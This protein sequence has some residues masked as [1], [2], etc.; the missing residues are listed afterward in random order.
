MRFRFQPGDTVTIVRSG[1]TM[2]GNCA[3]GWNALGMDQFVGDGKLYTIKERVPD[4]SRDLPAYHVVENRWS[5]D[6]R[7]LAAV[8]EPL[9]KPE[10]DLS[11][12]FKAV[13]K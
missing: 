1:K 10:K 4:Y 11:V 13:E 12:F 7:C 5:W 6:E 3:H 9:D 8:E 2:G